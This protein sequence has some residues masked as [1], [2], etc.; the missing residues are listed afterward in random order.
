MAELEKKL[1]VRKAL[2]KE[3][4]KLGRE[5]YK[6]SHAKSISMAENMLNEYA[7]EQKRYVKEL[8]KCVKEQIKY[9]KTVIIYV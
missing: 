4:E 6:Q 2:A 7:K 8:K 1:K 3:Y 5:F 9:I